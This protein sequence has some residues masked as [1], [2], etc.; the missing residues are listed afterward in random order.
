MTRFKNWQ[1]PELEDGKPCEYGWVVKGVENFILEENTDIGYGTYI[2]AQEG[3]TIERDVQ[4]GGGCYIYSVNTIDNKRG[5]II[6]KAGARVGAGSIIFPNVTIGEGAII[7]AGT[8]VPGDV[9]DGHTVWEDKSWKCRY[10]IR[11]NTSIR[12]WYWEKK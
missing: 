6:I 1:A 8:I 11:N 5:P 12:P 3:V 9:P 10:K 2:Q 4:I 7:G